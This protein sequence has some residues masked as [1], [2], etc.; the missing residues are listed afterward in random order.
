MELVLLQIK[1]LQA[2]ELVEDVMGEGGQ[3][4]AVHVKALQLLQPTESSTL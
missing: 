1:V 2:V 4:A 3:T